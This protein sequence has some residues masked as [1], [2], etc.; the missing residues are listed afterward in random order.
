MLSNHVTPPSTENDAEGKHTLT[1][2][3]PAPRYWHSLHQ[4]TRAERGASVTENR[5]A[6]HRHP[7]D[8][9]IKLLYR[10]ESGA[11]LNAEVIPLGRVMRWGSSAA[12]TGSVPK[13][14]APQ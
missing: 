9:A 11:S 2:P 4:H 13:R 10:I 7:P 12:L 14:T 3:L 5:T 6:L 1:M 8:V